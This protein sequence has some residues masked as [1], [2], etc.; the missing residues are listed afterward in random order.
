MSV[1]SVLAGKVICGHCGHTMRLSNTK[2]AAFHCW[3]THFAAD[4]ACY[5]LRI[6]Q[7]ELEETVRES[8]TR[9]AA[10]VLDAGKSAAVAFRPPAVSEQEGGLEKLRDEKRRLYESFVPSGIDQDGYRIRKSAVDAELER[11]G[12]GSWEELKSLCF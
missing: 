5:G 4:A 3:F 10:A 12:G 8:V 11:L 7:G 9:Q 2:S 1:T 6:L